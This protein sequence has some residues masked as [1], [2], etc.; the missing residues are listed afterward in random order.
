[1]D[2]GSEE[3][4]VVISGSGNMGKNTRGESLHRIK[5]CSMWLCVEGAKRDTRGQ[6][7]VWGLPLQA[8]LKTLDF[9]L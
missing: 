1:M 2:K 9:N 3:V 8:I 6:M 7:G 4:S 5:S